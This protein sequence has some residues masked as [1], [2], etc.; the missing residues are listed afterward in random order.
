MLIGSPSQMT[1]EIGQ[2]LPA[3]LVQR[4]QAKPVKR[5]VTSACRVRSAR[6]IERLCRGP[7]VRS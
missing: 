5:C 1:C 6:S 7:L 2:G 3:L 4:I